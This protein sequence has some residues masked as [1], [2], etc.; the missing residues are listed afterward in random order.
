LREFEKVPVYNLGSSR[1]ALHESGE[2]Y[3]KAVS[4]WLESK[5]LIPYLNSA[6][7]G[8]F[9]DLL[10]YDHGQMKV[11]VECKNSDVRLHS[12]EFLIPFGWFLSQYAQLPQESRFRFLFVARSIKPFSEAERI[13]TLVDKKAPRELLEK[14]VEVMEKSKRELVR[15]AATC[16]ADIDD[17][18]LNSFIHSAEIV[19]ADYF[20]LKE[21][22]DDKTAI[23]SSSFLKS[24]SQP[25]ELAKRLDE[26]AKAS[27]QRETIASNI[28]SV[29]SMPTK[30]SYAPLSIEVSRASTLLEFIDGM[31]YSFI[32]REGK[33]ITFSDLTDT[34]NPLC[35]F[36]DYEKIKS[37]DI[38][39][40]FDGK[41]K[42]RGLM[43]LMNECLFR[44]LRKL[45]MRR[46]QRKSFFFEAKDGK[47]LIIKWNTG[48]KKAPRSITY[49]KG[50]EGQRGYWKHRALSAFFR[51]M[52]GHYYLVLKPCFFFSKDGVKPVSPRLMTRLSSGAWARHGNHPLFRDLRFWMTFL[53][54]C[55]SRLNLVTGGKPIEIDVHPNTSELGYGIPEDALPHLVSRIER[56][57]YRMFWK[58]RDTTIQTT[59]DGEPMYDVGEMDSLEDIEEVAEDD[60]FAWD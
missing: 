25:H 16:L 31:P 59:L 5:G 32:L 29:V 2:R 24:L 9:E 53:S 47:Q 41:D 1:E 3:K 33:L 20:R 34:E 40:V 58:S 18:T 36:V 19:Q 37:D 28:F 7:E 14:A 52:D 46:H 23:P 50:K 13:F 38:G 10:F 55:G 26:M 22:T 51:E 8:T 54:N 56:P 57:Q 27:S 15:D 44:H 49:Y 39:N 60:D 30:V 11:V 43:Q 48:L 12:K 35:E 45:E 42:K 21:I 4:D 17:A 6:I